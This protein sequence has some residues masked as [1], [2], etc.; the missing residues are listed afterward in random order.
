MSADELSA[1][2]GRLP[3]PMAARP[4]LCSLQ[5]LVD[6]HTKIVVEVHL[7]LPAHRVEGSPGGIVIDAVACAGLS[8]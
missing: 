1:S 8:P 6:S 7:S 2:S 5:N 3:W 4:L